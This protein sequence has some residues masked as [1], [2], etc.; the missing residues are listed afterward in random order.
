MRIWQFLSGYVMIRVEGLSLERFLN[1]AAAEGIGVRRAR[2]TSY[3]VLKAE[4]TARGYRKLRRVV[5]ERYAVTAER[6]G[7]LP[8]ALRA[9]TLR[10][11]LLAGLVLVAGGLFVV[12]LFVWDVRVDG[13]EYREAKALGGRAFCDGHPPR[14]VEGRYRRGRRGITDADRARGIRLDRHPD[15][16]RRGAREGCPR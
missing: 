1:L 14:C 10:T 6:Q 15:R 5:P 9:L 2:R 11:A 12:S 4:V 16:R 3:T 8:F 13:L 7:G